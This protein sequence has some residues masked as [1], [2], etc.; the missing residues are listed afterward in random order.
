M[1]EGP[2]AAS[3]SR[4]SIRR[5]PEPVIV[6]AIAELGLPAASP[7]LVRQT[8]IVPCLTANATASSFECTRSLPR[9]LRTWV[10]TVWGL[11]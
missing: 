5:E 10:C 4:R 3:P 6:I 1:T 8:V 2:D 7:S 11:M 9:M